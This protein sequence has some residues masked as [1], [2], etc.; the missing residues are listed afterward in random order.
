MTAEQMWAEFTAAHGANDMEY[1]AW[2]FG[3]D[4]D[5]LARLALSGDKTA[6]SSAFPCYELEGE[7]LPEAG[8]YSVI[9]N[10][11]GEAVCVIQTGRVSV[12]PYREVSA[13]HARREGEGD[14]SLAYWRQVHEAFFTRE[15]AGLGL[16]FTPD[17]PVVC[18]EFRRVWPEESGDG[19]VD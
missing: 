1:D 15:L 11:R 12:A 17:M 4:A 2:A 6:T 7:P 16:V 5:L 14:L 13:E 9:L 19:N 10:S 8:T 18:E 3:G